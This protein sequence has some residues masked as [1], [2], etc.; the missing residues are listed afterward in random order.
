MGALLSG[1]CHWLYHSKTRTQALNDYLIDEVLAATAC[2][3]TYM[4]TD[5]A[6]QCTW[7]VM[8]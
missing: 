6:R 2:N 5:L 8:L 4:P 3:M 1:G 7:S